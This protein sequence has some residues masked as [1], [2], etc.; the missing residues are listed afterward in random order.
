M[1]VIQRSRYGKKNGLLRV[2]NLFLT[3]KIFKT[4]R[5]KRKS[6]ISSIEGDFFLVDPPNWVM[7]IPVIKNSNNQDCFLMVKQ[8]RHGSDSITLEFPAG[9]VDNNESS[10]NAATRELLEETG[11]KAGSIKQIGSINP[12]PAFMTN[13]TTTFLAE[14]LE[15]VGFQELDEHEEI[16][17]ELVPIS[18]FDSKISE[19][20]TGNSEVNSAITL[21][22]YL[23]Y[24][25]FVTLSKHFLTFGN[26]LKSIRV[27]SPPL[28][29]N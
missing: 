5:V 14:G 26:C 7:I 10:L 23:F 1:A 25:K 22:A 21:Q 16:D 19:F 11:F 27:L 29:V 8:Y 18:V 20:T 12:N 2:K 9:M 4:Y 28:I 6:D 13:C 3:T 15:K 17:F 24:L